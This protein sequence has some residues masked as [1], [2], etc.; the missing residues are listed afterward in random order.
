MYLS[1]AIALAGAV[2]L[3]AAHPFRASRRAVASFPAGSSWE[4][5]LNKGDINLSELSGTASSSVSAI[6]IDLFDNDEQTISSLKSQNKQVICYFS[7]GS[8]EEWR[9]DSS[10]F[11]SSDYG[12]GLEGWAG[13]NWVDV[14][15]QNVRDIMKARIKKAA[16][17]GCVA[18]DPDNVDGYVCDTCLVFVS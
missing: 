17:K 3:T 2:G 10:K 5:V 1:S 11:G 18:V 16:E 13:E 7:G 9:E 8:R 14:K 15:S 4:I 12:Q 6:D